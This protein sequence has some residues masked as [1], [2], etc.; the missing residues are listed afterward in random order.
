MG[1]FKSF[2]LP[3][4]RHCQ[5]RSYDLDKIC[6]VCEEGVSDLALLPCGHVFCSNRA[7]CVASGATRCPVC[8]MDVAN[9]HRVYFPQ[10]VA[11]EAVH[12]DPMLPPLPPAAANQHLA[13]TTMP[14]PRQP[15]QHQHF[16]FRYSPAQGARTHI[17][18]A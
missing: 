7:G 3:A 5:R 6:I 16:F 10:Y 18:F 1:T 11:D 13:P 17:F 9:T 12:I 14:F 8:K 15:Q 2:M 4:C